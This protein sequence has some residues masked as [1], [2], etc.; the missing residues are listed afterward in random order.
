MNPWQAPAHCDSSFHYALTESV[1]HT[2]THTHTPE[3][4]GGFMHAIIL[5]K[6]SE[7]LIMRLSDKDH[8][9]CTVRT[10]LSLCI[11][12]KSQLPLFQIGGVW[13]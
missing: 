10:L 4:N 7:L 11:I 8:M 6:D 5:R 13:C 9:G 3:D 2:H 1:M 12:V